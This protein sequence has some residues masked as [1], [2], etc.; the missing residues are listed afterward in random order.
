MNGRFAHAPQSSPE[1]GECECAVLV[2]AAF[3]VRDGGNASGNVFDLDGRTGF[4]PGLSAF[5]A[6]PACGD[7]KV[8]FVNN[9]L[10]WFRFTYDGDRNRACLN[11][12]VTFVRRHAL[13]TMPARFVIKNGNILA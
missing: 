7:L 12:T 13:K 5:S 3:P 2:L 6:S 11:A 10:L 4:V 9:E 1:D 8:A